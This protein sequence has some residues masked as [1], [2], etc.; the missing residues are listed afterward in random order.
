MI[1]NNRIIEFVNLIGLSISQGDI[2][3]A[4]NE[5]ELTQQELFSFNEIFQILQVEI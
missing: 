5:Y 2:D 4:L 1:N 3:I